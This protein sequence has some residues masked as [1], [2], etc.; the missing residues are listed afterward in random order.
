MALQLIPGLRQPLVPTSPGS[1]YM[2]RRRTAERTFRLGLHD[3]RDL[4]RTEADRAAFDELAGRL[5][6]SG[7]ELG[8]PALGSLAALASGWGR[9]LGGDPAGAPSVHRRTAELQSLL[10]LDR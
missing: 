1:S 5:E 9:V 8:V 7:E 4:V 3:L 10:G 6:R 2:K